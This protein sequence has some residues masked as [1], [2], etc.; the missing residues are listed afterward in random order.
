MHNLIK[1]F[2][3]D[4][5][6]PDELY[7]LRKETN[8]T[9]RKILVSSIREDWFDMDTPEICPDNETRF[10]I[11][12]NV[13]SS[14][15]LKRKFKTK[16]ISISVAA[17]VCMLAVMGIA[18]L[19]FES[20][21]VDTPLNFTTAENETATVALPDSSQIKLNQNSDLTYFPVVFKKSNREITFEGEGYFK[22][23]HDPKNPFTIKTGELVITVRGT[24]FNL[25]SNPRSDKSTLYLIEGNVEMYSRLSKRNINVLPGQLIEYYTATREFRVTTPR[26]TNNISSWYS[27][28]IRFDNEPLPEVLSFLEHHYNVRLRIASLPDNLRQDSLDGLYFNGTLPIKNL[29]LAIDALEKVYG[30]R[31]TYAK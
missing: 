25:S 9:S 12:E 11:L 19:D 27:G 18:Y 13:H 3:Q 14:I 4:D 28:E 15:R 30:I 6:S 1:K 20:N 8:G 22:I 7:R 16:I 21:V 26:T 17:C 5:I 10:R 23:A 31:L 29:P 2:R 24:E